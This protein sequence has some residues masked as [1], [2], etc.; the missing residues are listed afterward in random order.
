MRIL[1]LVLLAL[2]VPNLVHADGGPVSP[3][4]IPLSFLGTANGVPRTDAN[5]FVPVANSAT[6]V[7]PAAFG[8]VTIPN[9]APSV[10]IIGSARAVTV[11]LPATPNAAPLPIHVRA[12]PGQSGAQIT[13]VPA[14]G[15]MIS[16]GYA[17]SASP[18]VVNAASDLSLTYS[19]GVWSLDGAPAPASLSADFVN[20]VYSLG[21]QTPPTATTLSSLWT[22][23]NA[24]I[25]CTT[26]NVSG[27]IVDAACSTPR[28]LFDIS[29]NHSPLGLLFEPGSRN[30]L[31]SSISGIAWN[32]TSN[33]SP[34]LTTD[35]PPLYTGT[36]G[37]SAVYK[38]TAF[39][40]SGILAQIVI[41]L[42]N[43][44]TP[45]C[46][47][48]YVNIPATYTGG[49]FFMSLAGAAGTTWTQTITSPP[50]MSK[51]LQWQRTYVCG[52]QSATGNNLSVAL[53]QPLD[54]N[55]A[56]TVYVALPQLEVGLPGPTSFIPTLSAGSGAAETRTVDVVTPVSTALVDLS[57]G[58]GTLAAEFSTPWP[59]L[60]SAPEASVGLANV[61]TLASAA[62]IQA[63]G[64]PTQAHSALSVQAFGT[65]VLQLTGGPIA[66]AAP[67]RAI[68]ALAD[69]DISLNDATGINGAASN[70]AAFA[71]PAQL[72][73]V[74]IS[75]IS[76]IAVKN[77]AFYPARVQPVQMKSLT[78]S[79]GPYM[80]T[81]NP[82]APAATAI[83]LNF[84]GPSFENAHISENLF[85][86]PNCAPLQALYSA[87]GV[88][89][90]VRVG[91]T[92]NDDNTHARPTTA[93]IQAM[94]TC[95]QGFGPG[96]TL[97]WAL[98][99]SNDSPSTDA[100]EAAVVQTA[101]GA[102]NVLFVIGNE[103]DLYAGVTFS[104]FQTQWQSIH[105]AVVT[106]V[107]AA[108]F[109][110]P[111]SSSA[112]YGFVAQFNA[113]LGSQVVSLSAHNYMGSGAHPD[114]NTVPISWRTYS[115]DYTI[116]GQVATATA[117]AL[118]FRLTESG[119]IAGGTFST[120]NTL[121]GAL[122]DLWEMQIV[123]QAGAVGVNFHGGFNGAGYS[124]QIQISPVATGT[125]FQPQA[126][127]YAMK[128]FQGL[129]GG[130]VIP[131][132]SAAPQHVPVLGVLGA[133]GNTRLLILNK[134]TTSAVTVNVAS[135]GTWGSASVTLL[136]GPNYL[137]PVM[138]IGG[139]SISNSGALTSVP[140]SV[141]KVGGMAPVTIPASS[142]ALVT[143]Q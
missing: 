92:T 27:L 40:A 118:P 55:T 102:G 66:G 41:N 61:G 121:G 38:S 132:A 126:A 72:A 115:G 25:N 84:I 32:L 74:T 20:G 107:P 39:P 70:S 103:P 63:F 18:L 88:N 141:A 59:T 17:T 9:G 1:A 64:D 137:S 129:V 29:G 52:T 89:G 91:G 8:T 3:P 12:T 22:L 28:Q 13:L 81:A 19:G 105:D 78:N 71:L 94:A 37:T 76:S 138:T 87:L 57:N 140:F 53:R 54:S 43:I 111:D 69:N 65:Q 135:T 90:V 67:F 30:F 26:V 122:L 110:G 24:G 11:N 142:A 134:S 14:A 50:D 119:A 113:A 97:I 42:G 82:S 79:T 46:F 31:T 109:A 86:P 143:L 99:Y 62:N 7:A 136:T 68:A 48:L 112:N 10:Q 6:V 21:Y 73:Q 96:W 128:L 35:L 131:V 44:N 56:D 47:S 114:A 45:V 51:R 60:T 101:M 58:G 100:A 4:G 85:G 124:P 23:T 34:A 2:A 77:I 120:A 127:F 33:G 75:P 139:G 130:Q 5:N 117:A 16:N 93:Q 83:P 104:Q 123:A 95:I 49:A 116:R 98:N 80:M 106:S 133:D 108:K 15:Q 36:V 125:P